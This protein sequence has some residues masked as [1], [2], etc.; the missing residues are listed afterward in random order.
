MAAWLAICQAR[1]EMKEIYSFGG[2]WGC[3]SSESFFLNDTRL[4][5]GETLGECDDEAEEE[6]STDSMDEAG[7]E[8][9][10][11]SVSIFFLSRGEE[12]FFF[13][14]G[15]GDFSVLARTR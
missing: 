9:G 6:E 8:S 15:E 10:V 11:A 7:F 3:C 13:A 1:F 14:R 12:D 4:V 2:V 5:R